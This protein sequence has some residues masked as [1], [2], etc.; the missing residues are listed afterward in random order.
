M[1]TVHVNN[2]N[3][4]KEVLQSE[5][6]VLLDFWADW[7]GPCRM[8]APILDEIA[9]ERSDIKIVKINVEEAPELATQYRIG[10]I[11]TLI[12]MRQG[13]VVNRAIGARSK[14]QILDLL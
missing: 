12:V 1:K 3:Y 2:D 4:Q 14:N 11:P 13:T 7:C 10:S 9:A 8:V 6:T 5:Q